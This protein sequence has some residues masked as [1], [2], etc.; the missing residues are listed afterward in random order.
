MNSMCRE[1][2][3]VDLFACVELVCRHVN[4]Y[5]I[6]LAKHRMNFRLIKFRGQQENINPELKGSK[7]N[8]QVLEVTWG[9]L[10][11]NNSIII[12]K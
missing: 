6:A 10:S 11:G 3:R 5:Y 7:L 1:Y 4:V 9:S 2:Q 8:H 12:I